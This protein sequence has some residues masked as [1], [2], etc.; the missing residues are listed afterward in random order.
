[1][2]THADAVLAL[3]DLVTMRSAITIAAV[4]A[5]LS[6]TSSR[7]ASPRSRFRTKRGGV[8][9]WRLVS[10][11]APGGIGG[12]CLDTIF[13]CPALDIYQTK[14]E[15]AKSVSSALFRGENSS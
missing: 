6:L 3:L 11:A 2:Y 7:M 14:I 5:G 12:L 4:G 9:R 10:A 1:M 13:A 15:E 8:S